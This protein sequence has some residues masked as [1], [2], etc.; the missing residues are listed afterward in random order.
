MQ[1]CPLV[2]LSQYVKKEFA[3]AKKTKVNELVGC[4]DFNYTQ[5]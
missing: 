4:D 1:L 5:D 2:S 3:M